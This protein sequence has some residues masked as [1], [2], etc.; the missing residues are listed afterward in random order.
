MPRVQIS[1]QYCACYGR[2]GIDKPPSNCTGDRD[3]HCNRGC[4]KFFC[5]ACYL[6]STRHICDLSKNV[7][8]PPIAVK[9]K[10]EHAG[11]GATLVELGEDPNYK[12]P[13]GLKLAAIE[14]KDDL[15]S[16]ESDSDDSETE[17]DAIGQ[18]E[19]EAAATAWTTFMQSKGNET[20]AEPHGL[21]RDR[22]QRDNNRGREGRQKRSHHNHSDP[23]TV[24]PAVRAAEYPGE[25][26]DVKSMGWDFFLAQTIRL[27]TWALC[28]RDVALLIPSSG[29]IERAF[30]LLTQGFDD[31]QN[32]ALEDY[33]C[34]AVKLKYNSI[35]REKEV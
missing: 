28:A 14:Q 24:T 30:S 10:S 15:S 22:K 3:T 33:K 12:Q 7:L 5:G 8:P 31:Q 13:K 25:G 21:A 16:S 23:P 34:T 1:K 2:P 32:A 26:L 18:L 11:W 9:R 19:G 35:W 20:D 4:Y 29:T 6:D 17:K 27:P